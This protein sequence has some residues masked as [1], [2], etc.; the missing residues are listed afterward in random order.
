[1]CFLVSSVS[2][3]T[4][5]MAQYRHSQ[6]GSLNLY[7]RSRPGTENLVSLTAGLQLPHTALSPTQLDSSRTQ[8]NP[9]CLLR[10]EWM[11]E[12]MRGELWTTLQRS[13]MACLRGKELPCVPRLKV[14][15]HDTEEC[16]QWYYTVYHGLR[17]KTQG[18]SWKAKLREKVKWM[19]KAWL[20]LPRPV[21][22]L[23]FFFIR[24]RLLP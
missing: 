22:Q 9:H 6:V 23:I 5:C 16:N 10:N 1:M 18:K 19:K 8:H 13:S 3:T 15:H 2:E 17:S 21:P 4:L 11:N 7:H 20:N 14:M 12:W 24:G